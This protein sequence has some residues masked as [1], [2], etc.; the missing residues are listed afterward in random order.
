[1]ENEVSKLL[2]PRVCA[3]DLDFCLTGMAFCRMDVRAF[4]CV[5]RDIV[6]LCSSVFFVVGR[7]V[8]QDLLDRLTQTMNEMPEDYGVNGNGLEIVSRQLIVAF[9]SCNIS[10][11]FFKG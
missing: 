3:Q 8:L 1:M 7:N 4:H 9:I 2:E 5:N 10:A 6:L 11:D